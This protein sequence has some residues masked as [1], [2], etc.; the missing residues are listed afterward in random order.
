MKEKILLAVLLLLHLF[1]HKCTAQIPETKFNLVVG[2]NGEPLS[3]IIGITQ[4]PH[5]YM[6]FAG[7]MPGCLY[8]YDGNRVV[9][10]KHDSLNSNSLGGTNPETVYADANGMI[11][12]GFYE[13][14]MDQ[15]NPETGIFKHF[16][17]NP[18]DPE[19]LSEG[20]ISVILKD[21]LGRL[22][23]GTENGLDRLDEKT[24]K[25]IHCRS[26]PGNLSSLSNNTVRALYEDRKGVLWV[27]TGWEFSNNNPNDG[28]LN[29]MELNGKFTRFLHDPNNPNSL[30]NNK[31]RV[32]FEDS[33]GVFWIGTSG[34][35]LHT[36]DRE[37]G[38]IKRHAFNPIKSDQLSRPPLKGGGNYDPITFIV[39]DSSGAIWIGSY[40]SGVNRYDTSSKRIIHFESSHGFPDKSCWMAYT[41]RD[42][43]LWLATQ[44]PNLF[45]VDP[46]RRKINHINTGGLV[47][48]FLEDKDGFLWI[49]N[50]SK[51]LQKFDRHNNL[52]YQLGSKPLD[53]FGLSSNV[54]FYLYQNQKDSI[55]LS[56]ER[57]INIFNKKTNKFFRLNIDFKIRDRFNDRIFRIL[58][59]KRGSKWFATN[60]GLIKYNTEDGSVKQYIN[61]AQDTGSISSKEISSVLEDREGGIWAG[62]V[63]G[64]TGINLL[65][66]R[67]DRFTHFMNGYSVS[68]MY[69]DG[70]G[71]IWAGTYDHGLFRYNKI[72]GTFLPFFES[73][74]G[75]GTLSVFSIIEDDFKNLW[76]STRL[77][78][79]KIDSARK[80]TL[81]Y[82]SEFGIAPNGLNNFYKSRNGRILLGNS[83][84]FYE[85]YPQDIRGRRQP[86]KILIT[87]FYIYNLKEF[88]KKEGPLVKPIEESNE[89]KLKYN[90]NYFSFHFATVDYRAPESSKYLTML[91]NYD[92]VW[93]EANGDKAANYINVPP[94]K[95][96]F[97]IKAYNI[98]GVKT[99]IEIH[100][101]INPPWW[102]T[103]WAYGFYGI[104][105]LTTIFWIHRFQKQRTI[106]IERQKA[107][108]KEL[109]QAK[110]IEKAY[111]E[112]KTTQ[113]Q[114]IQ[115]EKMA[116]LGELTAGIAHEIQNPLNFINNFSEVNKEL[117]EEME[118][119]IENGSKENLRSI[120]TDVKNNEEKISHHGKR[121]DAIVK[122][123]LQHSRTSSGQKEPTD[124]NALA[125]EY[126]SLSYHGLR[127]KDKSFN[128]TLQTDFDPTIGKINI[129][130]QDIG[131]VLLNLYNNAFYA[132]TEK[133]KQQPEEY[134]PAVSVTTKRI[135][136]KVLISVKDNGGG[137]PQKIK[138][139][140]FQP[141]FTTKPAGQGTG[142]GL[143]LS[144][145]IVKALDGKLE[146]E[147]IEGNGAEF[148]VQ[149]P[150]G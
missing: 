79:L 33:R 150:S 4:D 30:I 67:T 135:G 107:Q 72:S 74:G 95:Y 1:S 11:W 41:S 35:G 31:V 73:E 7:K 96:T 100:I 92:N 37:K 143:S 42:G 147:T 64:Q 146:V 113:A 84:G 125:D 104:L 27:G 127:A 112:L 82:G 144:Y 18:K 140:I 149:I 66:R 2:N 105:L 87:D 136:E 57:G 90:Q 141:F 121:A 55:W 54:I 93:R 8:R 108:V 111:T 68:C 97:R 126:L 118:Q 122:G 29:R 81:I 51:G 128:A 59:D 131:R 86:L 6:W 5:G 83:D 77:F 145:D 52:V 137:I 58:Q 43:V 139:K 75:N 115:S 124:I 71:T 21:H 16:H 117:I 47:V 70:E 32:I 9:T 114:L 61:D 39:E 15:Y 76:I 10:F 20:I 120:A 45:R 65:N 119:E 23:V 17:N 148:V 98:D 44:E 102:K 116:S 80:E 56:T 3:R 130:S 36:M 28:G 94:G 49:G 89:I 103:W 53:S 132:V 106:R 62:A 19:S 25:F 22:W 142:L 109:A 40:A 60:H 78:I 88:A 48:S 101:V 123:M 34:D 24:G 91:D 69:E 14:G 38:I 129:I 50:W 138:D 85:F 63:E 46:F 26:E 110:E 134:E 13:S 133:K 99:E 12:I